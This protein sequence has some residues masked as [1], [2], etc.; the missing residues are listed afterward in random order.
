MANRLRYVLMQPRYHAIRRLH[1]MV[2]MRRPAPAYLCLR[3]TSQAGGHRLQKPCTTS[4][5][6][7]AGAAV[8]LRPLPPHMPA[9][10]CKPAAPLLPP[11]ELHL[12]AINHRLKSESCHPTACRNSWCASHTAVHWCTTGRC[13]SHAKQYS[14]Q[15]TSFTDAATT[16]RHQHSNTTANN[17]TPAIAAQTTQRGSTS[18]C[19]HSN[20]IRGQHGTCYVLPPGYIQY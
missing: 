18:G 17:Y 6:P 3:I 11:A 20:A 14:R 13:Q 5:L 10:R 12:S 7:C 8:T 16:R 9:P 4:T 15:H 19:L 2:H 1:T